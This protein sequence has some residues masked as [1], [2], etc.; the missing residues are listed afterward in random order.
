MNLDDLIAEGEALSKPCY[1]LSFTPTESGIVGYWNGERAD[2]PDMLPAE[3]TAFSNSRHIVTIHESLFAELDLI[4]H[5]PIGL[6]ELTYANDTGWQH[7]VEHDGRLSFGDLEC[8]G[9]PLYATRAT[10]FP[11]FP[12][13]CLH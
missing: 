11:P 9:L 12:A 6:F 7:R 8:T 10:S 3:V 4:R 13:V 5:G 2:H 1:H